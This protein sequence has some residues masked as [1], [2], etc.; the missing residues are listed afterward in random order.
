VPVTAPAGTTAAFDEPAHTVWLVKLLTV[1][2]GLTVIVNVVAGELVQPLFVPVTEMVAVIG[3][4]EVFTAVKAAIFPDPV[5]V[6]PID[7]VLF[8]QA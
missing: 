6:K 3:A 7:G 4:D 1:G 8:V 2:V 5:A